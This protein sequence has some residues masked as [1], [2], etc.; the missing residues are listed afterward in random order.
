MS[1]FILNSVLALQIIWRLG[2]PGISEWRVAWLQC[3]L[4]AGEPEISVP[5]EAEHRRTKTDPQFAGLCL[6]DQAAKRMG[7]L[8]AWC[9]V[10][11]GVLSTQN[12]CLVNFI[13]L[14]AKIIPD[15]WRCFSFWHQVFFFGD[16][17]LFIAHFSILSPA[18]HSMCRGVICFG[19][20]N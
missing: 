1:A 15:N 12:T 11:K 8:A 18:N 17:L 6:K 13:L 2:W 16:F 3:F 7:I 20:M 19:T 14:V 5:S 4:I 10:Y 9:S